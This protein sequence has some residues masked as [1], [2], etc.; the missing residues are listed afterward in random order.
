MAD[1]TRCHLISKI[2]DVIGY[3]G[4]EIT[5][6]GGIKLYIPP[7][8]LPDPAEVTLG[9]SFDPNHHPKVCPP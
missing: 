9:V 7:N 5:L 8:A 3:S 2:S 6:E 1:R 4:G